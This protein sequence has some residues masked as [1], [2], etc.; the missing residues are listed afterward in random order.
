[1]RKRN[2]KKILPGVTKRVFL[3]AFILWLACMYVITAVAAEGIFV[4]FVNMGERFSDRPASLAGIEYY[5]DEVPERLPGYENYVVW[6]AMRTGKLSSYYSNWLTESGHPK[7]QN[8]DAI[9][10][11]TAVAVFDYEGRLLAYP[12]NFLYFPYFYED[13][14]NAGNHTPEGYAVCVLDNQVDQSMARHIISQTF[15]SLLHTTLCYRFTGVLEDGFF[16][17]YKI[18]YCLDGKYTD[19]DFPEWTD[20]PSFGI[21][22]PEGVATVTLYSSMV[23]ANSYMPSPSFVFQGEKMRDLSDFLKQFGPG[24][25]H[26]RGG[27]FKL[28][29][30][31]YRSVWFYHDKAELELAAAEERAPEFKYKAV[32]AIFGSPWESAIA[33][34]RNVYIVS[35]LM[36]F[37]LA[38]GVRVRL[39]R[40]VIEP[41][42]TVNG[43]VAGGWS[44]IYVA[45]ER[46]E[47]YQEIG[48]L[49]ENYQNT[50]RALSRNKDTITRLERALSFAQEAEENR[51]RMTSNIAH[52]LKTPLAVIHSYAEGLSERIAED[53]RDKYLGIILSETERMDGMVLEMLDLS[54]LEAGKVKLARED[55]SL[56]EITASVF[57]RLELA[58]AAKEL[59]LTTALA[60][61]CIITADPVR[62]EQ[63]I[64]NF[65]INAVKYTPFGGSIRVRTALHRKTVT[66]A[67]EN[68]SPP[69]SKEAL[70]RVWE[71]FYSAEASRTGSGTG[72]GL[73]IAKSVIEL[74]GGKCYARNTK[75]GVEFSFSLEQ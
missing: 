2:Q 49:I 38:L 26:G 60:E 66:F 3:I 7:L 9:T 22:A 30:F 27:Q 47:K 40:H 74:H 46:P 21:E 31:V 29:N 56:S 34:L 69:L 70:L 6:Q 23:R 12:S 75:P 53:K 73:A 35:F 67:M 57:E 11:D 5:L 54:R 16:T 44:N 36:L 25:E 28:G 52:E 15:G 1:M 39:K 48:E 58:L 17:L 19:S 32:S 37:F 71:T 8:W 51:R 10:A 13:G 41:L 63:V 64:T 59:T 42:A 4:E 20:A 33:S 68:D 43:A 62:I 24:F 72:L 65:A 18:E 50:Q 55:F 61:D 14:Y 45:E